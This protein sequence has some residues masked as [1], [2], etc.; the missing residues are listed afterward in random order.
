MRRNVLAARNAYQRALWEPLPWTS[1]LKNPSFANNVEHV[2][3][4]VHM[5]A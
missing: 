4:F 5:N 1:K 2:C 3:S